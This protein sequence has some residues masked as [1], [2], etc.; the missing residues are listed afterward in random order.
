[1]SNQL[2]LGVGGI[3]LPHLN[4]CRLKTEGLKSVCCWFRRKPILEENIFAA[5]W[6]GESVSEVSWIIMH[7]LST[8]RLVLFMGQILC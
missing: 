4:L 8:S 7:Q 5:Q 1:M 6:E 3:A 2:K